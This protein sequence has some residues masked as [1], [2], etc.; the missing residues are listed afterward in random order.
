[1]SDQV[2]SWIE[3]FN[4]PD[5]ATRLTAINTAITK[6]VSA[7]REDRECLHEAA[8]NLLDDPDPVIQAKAIT[9]LSRLKTRQDETFR[10]FIALIKADNAD[11]VHKAAL[12]SLHFVRPSVHRRLIPVRDLFSD[13]IEARPAQA[14]LLRDALKAL[15]F[16]IDLRDQKCFK[17]ERTQDYIWLT[18]CLNCQK[19]V[20]KDHAYHVSYCSETCYRDY[21]TERFGTNP[22][23]W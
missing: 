15:G 22:Q 18:T 20:C 7:S 21:N 9:M 23:Y 12:Q 13:L 14:D 10:L 17:C 3:T 8:W 4:D 16:N 11:I 6:G 2:D 19:V 1:M 5:R